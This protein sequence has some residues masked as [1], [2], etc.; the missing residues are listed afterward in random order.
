MRI[1]RYKLTQF[2]PFA[3]TSTLHMSVICGVRREVQLHGSERRVKGEGGTFGASISIALPILEIALFLFRKNS[4]FIRLG[5]HFVLVP[6]TLICPT[7]LIG[8]KTEDTTLLLTGIT[9]KHR[10]LSL[11]LRRNWNLNA[12]ASK[13]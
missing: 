5:V 11:S 7:Q 10:I 2:Q 4:I 13:T 3:W 6:G 1:N 9:L 8:N 12:E